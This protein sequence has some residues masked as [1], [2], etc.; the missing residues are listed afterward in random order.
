[1]VSSFGGVTTHSQSSNELVSFVSS[2]LTRG[3]R[4]AW[5][6]ARNSSR[7]ALVGA[8]GEFEE[9]PL[10]G[11]SSG[12]R[13]AGRKELVSF[14]SDEL[15]RG[16][17]WAWRR[18]RDSSCDAGRCVHMESAEMSFEMGEVVVIVCCAKG[19]GKRVRRGR[20]FWRI[21]WLDFGC[22]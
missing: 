20:V 8:E 7:D 12:A 19:L 3:A 13:S 17:R 2:E 18:A 10:E 22:S 5:R 4:S 11:A 14:A 16:L 9:E 6:R 1:V 21:R 15:T